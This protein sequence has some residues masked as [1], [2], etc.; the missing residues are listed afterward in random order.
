MKSCPELGTLEVVPWRWSSG[1]V[2]LEGFAWK[3][4]A[5]GSPRRSSDLGDQ[6]EGFPEGGPLERV[7]R[8]APLK[9]IP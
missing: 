6:T 7:A 8:R 1:R 5:G 4:S 9:A 2:P 3:E